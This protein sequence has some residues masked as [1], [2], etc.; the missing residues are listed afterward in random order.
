MSDD[1][2]GRID[3]LI[4]VGLRIA[5]SARTGRILMARI[6][7]TI[8]LDWIPR[9]WGTSIA[10]E[11][12]AASDASREPI[13][14]KR[15]ERILRDAWEVPAS[16]ELDEL[17]ADPVAVTPGAQVHRGVLEGKPVAVKVLRPGLASAVRQDL[18]LLEGLMGPLSSAFPALDAAAL[19]RELRERTLEELDLESEATA[20]RRVHRA[21]RNHPFLSVPAPV[22]R[23]AHEDVLVSEWV[24]GSSFWEAEDPDAAAARLIVFSFGAARFGLV[25]AELTP[26]DVLVLPDGGLA[27]IDFGATAQLP[28]ERLN[29]MAAAVEAFAADDVSAFGTALVQ[30]GSLPA[31]HAALALNVARHA[32]GPLASTEPSRLDSPAVIAARDR[33]FQCEAELGEL[34]NAG[35]L[36]P[37][38]LWPARSSA[39]LFATI[40]RVGA[41]G[42]WLELVRGA[43]SQGWEYRP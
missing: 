6:A 16:D 11:L 42:P 39:Q 40:A 3:S 36:P 21:L 35:T 23:L 30:L 37:E 4:A 34:I 10:A 14:F 1:T 19:L 8:D 31:E 13:P 41:S 26:E 17:E 38:D 24:D 20:M 22:M 43:L 33:L 5:R 15:V 9:P 32:L 29:L 25:H 27:I 7:D 18:V 2:F 12:R 28:A